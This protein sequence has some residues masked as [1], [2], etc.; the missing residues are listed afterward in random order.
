MVKSGELAKYQ[1]AIVAHLIN[2]LGQVAIGYNIGCELEKKIKM[3]PVLKD[4]ARNKG[5]R[6]LVS[7][8]HRHSHNR[9]CGIDNLTI[10][11]NALAPT[12]CYTTR[13]RRQQAIT[14]Y[15]KHTNTFNTYQGST[16]ILCNKYWHA[17][18]IRATHDVL[19][20]S[21]QELGV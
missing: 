16:L 14:I 9:R 19:H 17:L 3:H 6:A 8:F 5:F 10:Y 18:E 7:A 11:L 13:L 15:L 1:L 20:E 2:I 4:I 21:M 12:T